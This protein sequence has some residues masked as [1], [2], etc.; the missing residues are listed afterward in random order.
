MNKKNKSYFP[1]LIDLTQYKSLVIGGGSIATRKVLNLLEFGARPDIISPEIIDELASLIV[2]NDLIHKKRKYEVGDANDYN[3]IFSATGDKQLDELL[4]EECYGTGS[5]LNIADVPQLCNFI[6]PATIKRG[7]FTFSIASQGESP[8][9]VK[10]LRKKLSA[11]LPANLEKIS[12]LAS[13]LRERMFEENIY[14]KVN[15]REELIKDFLSIDWYELL[16]KIDIEEAKMIV[17]A[18]ILEYVND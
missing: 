13:E 9:M 6:M 15:Q 18:M 3:L 16:D 10:H 8:F 2:S 11:E 12:E 7:S 17:E 5:L 4:K 1:V 14:D